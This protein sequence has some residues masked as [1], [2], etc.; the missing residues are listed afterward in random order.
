[1]EDTG[2]EVHHVNGEQ[3][4]GKVRELAHEGSVRRIIIKTADGHTILEI[5]LAIG[6]AAALL[7]PTLVAVA[8]IAALAADYTV[9]VERHEQEEAAS[10]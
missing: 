10:R 5:P 7:S 2:A 3:L 8:A 9:V 6:V 4:L 1:M